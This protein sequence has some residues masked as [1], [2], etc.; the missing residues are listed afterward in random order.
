MAGLKGF[1][2][3]GSDQPLCSTQKRPLVASRT[4]VPDDLA[5]WLEDDMPAKKKRPSLEQIASSSGQKSDENCPPYPTTDIIPSPPPKEAGNQRRQPAVSMES[6]HAPPKKPAAPEENSMSKLN[7]KPTGF[8][9]KINRIYN[10]APSPVLQPH[11]ASA[12]ST[13]SAVIVIDPPAPLPTSAATSGSISRVRVKV[14]DQLMLVPLA[15]PHLTIGNLAQE[16]SRRYCRARGGAEPVLCLSTSDGALLDAGDFVSDVVDAQDPILIGK[17]ESWITK[18]AEERYADFC[19]ARSLTN[20]KNLHTKL[21]AIEASYEFILESSPLRNQQGDAVLV[22]LTSCP[23]LRSLT[24]NGC[25]LT[26]SCLP[27][28]TT[29]IASLPSLTSL[30]LSTNMLSMAAL[31]RLASLSIPSLR[32]LDF[33]RNMLGDRPVPDLTKAFPGLSKLSLKSCYL[34]KPSIPGI[35]KLEY[36]DISLNQMAVTDLTNLISKLSRAQI[37]LLRGLTLPCEEESTK[38]VLATAWSKAFGEK[39]ESQTDSNDNIVLTLK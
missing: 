5:D 14:Q 8:Q 19:S 37:L 9:P 18:T 21:S 2:R 1:S 23:T 36:L 11:S 17:V 27:Q 13:S 24:L 10:R 35:E 28:L 20:F 12:S 31:D 33:S 32:S 7:K 3:R 29:C 15:S 30:D 39:A 16:A 26:D 34:A 22:A 6:I 25:K 38:A 4:N